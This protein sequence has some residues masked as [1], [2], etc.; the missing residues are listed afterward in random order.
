VAAADSNTT[1]A[2]DAAEASHT[3][4]L[5]AGASTGAK[6]GAHPDFLL[7][8]GEQSRNDFPAGGALPGL[9]ADER[10]S[11]KKTTKK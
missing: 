6:G 4:E 10:P 1:D 7:K 3:S 11:T 2:T 5:T 8:D 9:L